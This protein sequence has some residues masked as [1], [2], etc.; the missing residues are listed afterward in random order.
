M[1]TGGNSSSGGDS[2]FG[3]NS[4]SGGNNR[5]GGDSKFGGNDKSG[6]NGS[7]EA[8]AVPTTAVPVA[9]G[10]NGSSSGNGRHG[11]NSRSDGSGRFGDFDGSLLV[12]IFGQQ[13]RFEQQ[14]RTS[15]T[16]GRVGH[17]GKLAAMAGGKSNTTAT[18]TVDGKNDAE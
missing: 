3:G 2:S 16:N 1:A 13:R 12:A 14:Q 15:A 9:T 6:D 4:S 10:G 18:S 7:S 11:G 8:T 17:H 5:S